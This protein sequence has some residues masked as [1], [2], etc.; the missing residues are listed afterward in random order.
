MFAAELNRKKRINSLNLRLFADAIDRTVL[1]VVSI[2]AHVE[3]SE[4]RSGARAPREAYDW[5]ATAFE[6]HPFFLSEADRSW[7]PW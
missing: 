5:G 7:Q 3:E 4:L 6:Y 1:P 2:V